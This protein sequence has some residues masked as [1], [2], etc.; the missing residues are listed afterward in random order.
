MTHT[1]DKCG[2]TFERPGRKRLKRIFCS[3]ECYIKGVSAEGHW[4]WN[5]GRFLDD[6]GYV[7]VRVD[8]RHGKN[9]LRHYRMEHILVAERA[10][11]RPFRVGEMVHHVNDRKAE[12]RNSNLVIFKGHAYHR[13]LEAR[14][15]RIREFG[16]VQLRRCV[17]CRRIL[18]LDRFHR[19][20]TTFDGRRHECKECGKQQ[21]RLS[22]HKRWRQLRNAGIVGSG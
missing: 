11:G 22:Y 20:A 8:K 12:N 10:L 6:R 18:S 3:M 4:R 21:R 7:R 14:A 19:R 17:D 1:C 15:R 9:R 5:G 2:R 13:I 16:T